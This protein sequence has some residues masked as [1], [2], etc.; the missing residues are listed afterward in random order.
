MEKRAFLLPLLIFGIANPVWAH[1]P[2]TERGLIEILDDNDGEARDGEGK[3]GLINLNLFGDK[4]ESGNPERADSVIEVGGDNGN[5]QAGLIQIGGLVIGG[6]SGAGGLPLL[7]GLG[8][9][10]GN[11]LQGATG[12]GLPL[13]GASTTGGSTSGTQTSGAASQGGNIFQGLPLLGQ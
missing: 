5:E 12:S 7:G 11:I 2:I 9:G 4:A 6:S 3:A 13:L 8:G 10:G 1:G